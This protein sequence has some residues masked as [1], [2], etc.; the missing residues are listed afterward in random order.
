M[1]DPIE[2]PRYGRDDEGNY[3]RTYFAICPTLTIEVRIG[4]SHPDLAALAVMPAALDPREGN[5]IDCP[6]GK[7]HVLVEITPAAVAW[8]D[9]EPEE[10]DGALSVAERALRHQ[11]G[12]TS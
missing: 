6:C 11:N 1:S 12:A 3:V 4:L 9:A 7:Q 5:G 2:L 10:P 8:L